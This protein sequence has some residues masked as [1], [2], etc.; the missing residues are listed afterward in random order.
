MK[1]R[2][3]MPNFTKM[4]IKASFMKL[5]AEQPL[6][7]ITV[8][9]IVDDCG[10]NRNSF[11][12]HYQDIPTLMEEIVK[13]DVDA[14]IKKY[15]TISSI[16][17]CVDVAFRTAL[18]N[19]RAVMHIYNSAN[20]DIYERYMMNLCEY[21]VSAY[22][23]TA[24]GSNPMSPADRE[25]AVRFLKCELYGLIF[26]WLDGGMKDDAINDVRRILDVCRGLSD[27]IIRRSTE[28]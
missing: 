7:K 8:R 21:V 23:N 9:S 3:A 12:Y 28:K 22:L 17:E 14:L 15:P 4:A 13:D 10:I 16:D 5:I 11:Y 24:F 26:E 20:R 6:S 25:L 18:E 1:R 19:K 27:E 2:Y